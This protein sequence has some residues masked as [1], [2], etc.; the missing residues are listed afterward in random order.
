LV[1]AGK[2][3]KYFALFRNWILPFIHT[4]KNIDQLMLPKSTEEQAEFYSIIW[5]TKRW[6]LLFSLFFNK[7][8]MGKYGR[9]PAFLEQVN[10]PVSDFIYSKA[11]KQLSSTLAQEN[12]FLKMILTG[13]YGNE[14]PHYVRPENYKKI[15]D[16]IHYLHIKQ[17][18]VQ[19]VLNPDYHYFNL[20][21]IFEYMPVE[22]F[23]ACVQ[24]FNEK[25]P[26]GSRFAYWN[27]MVPRSLSNT[28]SDIYKQDTI[29]EQL[30][31]IDK[32]FFYNTFNIDQK[33]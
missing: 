24:N 4:K 11:A 18:F 8:V 30:T 26:Q 32:G 14:L 21:N 13:N 23:K 19:D 12:Y 3:E 20:S 9:D 2:F 6:K 22:V 31:N 5:N 25:S 7:Y 33:M 27:L 17:G 1:F 16:N 29:S 15:K 10:V 28:F